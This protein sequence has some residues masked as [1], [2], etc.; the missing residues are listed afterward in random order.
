MSQRPKELVGKA[1]GLANLIHYKKGQSG[2]PSGLK[3]KTVTWKA[4]EDLLRTALPRIMLMTEEELKK[5]L[6]DSPKGAEMLA[7]KYV[8]EYPTKCVDRFLGKVADVLTGADGMPLI[9]SPP[10]PVLPPM[11]FSG[12]TPDQ[13]ERFIIAV[14]PTPPVITSKQITQ[15]PSP[16]E[17]KTA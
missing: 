14:R 16:A 12:W 11:D 5:F 15:E 17:K 4:A 3:K 10:Q 7:L 13:V 1:K 2:N 6:K 9:P 8:R